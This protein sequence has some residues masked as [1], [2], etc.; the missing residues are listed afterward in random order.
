MPLQALKICLSNLISRHNIVFI[1]VKIPK[2]FDYNALL[3]FA[4]HDFASGINA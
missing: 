3:N 2:H 1:R 4:K